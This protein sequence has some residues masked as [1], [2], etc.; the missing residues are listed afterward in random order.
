MDLYLPRI[1]DF[2]LHL[3]FNKIEIS[4]HNEKIFIKEKRGGERDADQW[5]SGHVI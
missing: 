3:F 4:P 5:I 2:R 1:L